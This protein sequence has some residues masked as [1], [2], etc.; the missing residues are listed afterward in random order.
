LLSDFALQP[1]VPDLWLWRH[2]PGDG[3]TV[4]GAYNLLSQTAFSDE[5]VATYRFSI[6]FFSCHNQ[7]YEVG[8]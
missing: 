6:I 2:D 5:S 4:R 8:V 7:M 1:N 3:Y